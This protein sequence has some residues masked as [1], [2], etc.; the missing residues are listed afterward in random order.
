MLCI[1]MDVFLIIQDVIDV[2]QDYQLSISW[3]SWVY[4]V[5]EKMF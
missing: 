2:L 5:T 4:F 3:I 1:L